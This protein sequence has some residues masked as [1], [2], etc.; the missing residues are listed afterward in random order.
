MVERPFLRH[1]GATTKAPVGVCTGG[2]SSSFEFQIA[3]MVVWFQKPESSRVLWLLLQPFQDFVSTLFQHLNPLWWKYLKQFPFP[4]MQL[5]RSTESKVGSVGAWCT[6]P[7]VLLLISICPQPR[8]GEGQQ[9]QDCLVE[10]AQNMWSS[11]RVWILVPPLRTYLT[12]DTVFNHFGFL[13]PQCKNG[14]MLNN[15]IIYTVAIQ[16]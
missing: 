15:I 7:H 14:L 16:T 11:F 1:C 10:R 3:G 2:S 5:D 6:E 8:N 12:L 13:F 9:Q 4:A